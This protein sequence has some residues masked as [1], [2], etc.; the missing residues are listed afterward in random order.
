MTSVAAWLLTLSGLALVGIGGYFIIARPALLPED[1]RFMGTT[2]AALLKAAPD[3]SRW[4][5]R[6]FWVMGG[7]IVSTG[8]LVAYLA[9]T[10]LRSGE[11]GAL[12]VLA[13][14]WATSIGWMA[15]VNVVIDS[16]FKRPLLALAGLWAIALVLAAVAR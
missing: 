9:N 11:G 5:K 6:V 2:Q 14:V 12:V 4:L 1:A 13:L 8:V 3:L 16:D 15:L 10:S 7:Y